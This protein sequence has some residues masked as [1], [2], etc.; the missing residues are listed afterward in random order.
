MI[1]EVS[2]LYVLGASDP[3][4]EAIEKLLVGYGQPFVYAEIPGSPGKRVHP[5]CM[6]RAALPAD[7]PRAR[8]YVL[9][10][11]AFAEGG[12]GPAEGAEVITV[13]HH[14]PGD[15]GFGLPPHRFLEASSVGQVY[16]HLVARYGLTGCDD[17]RFATAWELDIDNTHT[18]YVDSSAT[19]GA[20]QR[21]ACEGVPMWIVHTA[22]A[23]HCLAA[24]YRGE[25]PGVDPDALMQYRAKARAAFQK[26][27]VEDILADIE[28]STKALHASQ[29]LYFGGLGVADMRRDPPFPELPE[30]AC[31][32]N[33]PYLAGPLK[34]PDG[35]MK[36]VISG[37]AEV[38]QAWLDGEGFAG[39]LSDRYG[40]PA[41]GFGGGYAS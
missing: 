4:M 28:Y 5:G 24:A 19:T 37:P 33:C 16:L 34:G 23:D 27:P 26:R 12:G 32:S 1:Q 11:C 31:R 25:C 14:R 20:I 6:Y 38:V 15:A 35:R 21:S 40:D 30:A 7:A 36:Y 10:E 41:R 22:A 3:E 13:D 17:L 2:H 39:N 8:N 18:W 29:L 9:V